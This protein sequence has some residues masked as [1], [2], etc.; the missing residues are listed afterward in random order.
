[1]T[2]KS[3]V[4]VLGVTGGIA[5]YKAAEL[6]S[7]LAKKD[8]EV[9]V[10]MTENALRFVGELTFRTLSKNPVVTS[11]WDRPQWQPEHVDLASR[12]SLFVVA[13]AT[14]DFIAKMACGIA[15]DALSTF[16]ATFSGATVVAPAMNPAMWAHPACR[17]NVAELV[18]RGVIFAGPETGHV[19]CGPDGT[20]RMSDPEK[21]LSLLP[22]L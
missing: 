1:M 10:I 2:K 15:D 9:H 16:A 21:I 11:L 5:A 6:C 19:A 13:P 8:V 17:R 14:A 7:L 18:S 3:P 4:V 12:A 20:G 22:G